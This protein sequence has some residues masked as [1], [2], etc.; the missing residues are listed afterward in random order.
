MYLVGLERKA[1]AA[2]LS[3]EEIQIKVWFQNRRIKY[4]KQKRCALKGQRQE[5]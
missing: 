1:L 5:H 4:R 3:L 2:K